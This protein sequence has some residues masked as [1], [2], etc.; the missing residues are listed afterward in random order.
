MRINRF[1]TELR[2]LAEEHEKITTKA[3]RLRYTAL[4]APAVNP[5]GWVCDRWPCCPFAKTPKDCPKGKQAQNKRKAEIRRDLRQGVK[6]GGYG[7]GIILLN[8]IFVL[9]FRITNCSRTESTDA[10]LRWLRLSTRWSFL[11]GAPYLCRYDEFCSLLTR[12][13]YRRSVIFWR[14]CARAQ[15]TA[16][17]R[18]QTSVKSGIINQIVCK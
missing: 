3:L 4:L 5:G 18:P 6:R 7:G 9:T 10:I 12:E 2:Q 16:F 13:R 8:T 15:L 1:N 14:M 11:I 17:G